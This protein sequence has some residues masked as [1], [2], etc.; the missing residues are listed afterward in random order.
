MLDQVA[1]NEPVALLNLDGVSRTARVM[2]T[3]AHF[4]GVEFDTPLDEA[5]LRMILVPPEEPE[6]PSGDLEIF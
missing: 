6:A 4:C 3:N 2:W 5:E 1:R